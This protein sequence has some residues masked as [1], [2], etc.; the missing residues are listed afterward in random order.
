[1]HMRSLLFG[2]LLS[3]LMLLGWAQPG[4]AGSKPSGDTPVKRAEAAIEPKR[5]EPPRNK[6]DADA[7]PAQPRAV[8]VVYPGPFTAAPR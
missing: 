1:M 8:R 4:G 5:V 2:G 6:H 7:L 3:S